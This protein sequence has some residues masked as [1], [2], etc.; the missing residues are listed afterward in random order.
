MSTTLLEA[1]G[2][3]FAGFVVTRFLLIQLI[4]KVVLL[5]EQRVNR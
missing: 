1:L 2:L 3:G 4:D 5:R